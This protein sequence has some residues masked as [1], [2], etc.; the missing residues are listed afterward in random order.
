MHNL[1]RVIFP[2]LLLLVIAVA[3][4]WY[5]TQAGAP[6]KVTPLQGSGTVEAVEVMV[7]PQVSGRVAEV[8]VAEGDAVQPGMPLFRL[9]DD[10]LNAQLQQATEP[11][12]E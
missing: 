1:R 10:I 7:S 5:L 11:G 6:Q 4:T 8:M 9:E 3:A 12:P 2:V